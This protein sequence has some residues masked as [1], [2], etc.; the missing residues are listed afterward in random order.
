MV[1]PSV[2]VLISSYMFCCQCCMIFSVLLTLRATFLQYGCS[3]LCDLT[4]FYL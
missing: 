2:C 4:V 1:S 3:V